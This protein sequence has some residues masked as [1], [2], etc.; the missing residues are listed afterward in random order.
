MKKLLLGKPEINHSSMSIILRHSFMRTHHLVNHETECHFSV[1]PYGKS[2]ETLVWLKASTTQN[3][4]WRIRGGGEVQL[5]CFVNFGTRWGGWSTP[6]FSYFTPGKETWYP[7]YR[8][9]GLDRSRKSHFPLECHPW[10]WQ[11]TTSIPTLQSQPTEKHWTR[12]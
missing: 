6:C 11:V 3:R 5:Y 12:L 7:W 1:L 4:P 8:R 10:A 9:L 2:W